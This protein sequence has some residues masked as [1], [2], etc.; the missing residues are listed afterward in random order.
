MY[1]LTVVTVPSHVFPVV[2]YPYK[3]LKTLAVTLFLI[4][5]L[6]TGCRSC[7]LSRLIRMCLECGNGIDSVAIVTNSKPESEFKKVSSYW[8]GGNFVLLMEVRKHHFQGGSYPI[9]GCYYNHPYFISENYVMKFEIV[10]CP[11]IEVRMERYC[12]V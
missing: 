6:I 11:F 8:R 10:I 12:A 2:L 1:R 3:R 9:I 4:S 7:R 5:W